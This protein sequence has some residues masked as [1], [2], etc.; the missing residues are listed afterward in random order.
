MTDTLNAEDG[1]EV[2]ELCFVVEGRF[3]A[4]LARDRFNEGCWPDAL[5]MLTDSFEGLTHEHAVAIVRGLADLS[6]TSADEKGIAYDELPADGPLALKMQA[7]CERLYGEV[8]RFRDAHY[9]PYAVVRGWCEEDFEFA[10]KADARRNMVGHWPST[11]MGAYFGAARSLFYADNRNADLVVLVPYPSKKHP[12]VVLAAKCEMPPLWVTPLK[13]DPDEVLKA[14]LERG[15]RWDER[16]AH[17]L[18][19]YVSDIGTA[20]EQGVEAEDEDARQEALAHAEA[21]ARARA[22]EEKAASQERANSADDASRQA[23]REARRAEAT[24]AAS[25]LITEY[26]E[27]VA[28]ATSSS[29]LSELGVQF[30]QRFEALSRDA[31]MACFDEADLKVRNELE[32]RYEHA[33]RQRVIEQAES[34]GGFFELS[35]RDE[36]GRD[37]KTGPAVLRVPLNPFLKWA[38]KGFDFEAYGHEVPVWNNVC[39]SGMK[40]MMDDPNHSDWML[41]AGLSLRDTYSADDES[42]P[43]RVMSAAY[44][45]RS[46]LVDE[47]TGCQFVPLAVA[48]GESWF[49]GEVV[50]PKPNEAVP[51]GSIAVVPTAGPEYQLAMQSACRPGS[52]GRPGLLVCNTGGRLAHLA[53]V[54]KE[55]GCTVLMV[56]NATAKFRKGQTVFV[57]LKEGTLRGF[58]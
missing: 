31:D 47:W 37:P 43:A 13:G 24:K 41:G 21:Q 11:P 48:K 45:K 22:Q 1:T 55:L 8:F 3:I 35:L 20:H 16:G 56:P 4:D 51:P 14:L 39:A 17:D 15:A 53:I 12:T 18:P 52:D 6:G 54:G 26:A 40:M 27:R 2:R 46:A 33:L 28:K 23:E 44:S 42:L 57:N 34:H 50:M 9:K 29:E 30:E 25:A 7:R 19:R 58:L 49:S 10:R 5:R 36:H 38:L 32:N